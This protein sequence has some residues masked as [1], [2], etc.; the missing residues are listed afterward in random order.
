MAD[1]D[2][3]PGNDGEPVPIR[4][5][6]PELLDHPPPGSGPVATFVHRRLGRRGGALVILAV[7]DLLFGAALVVT[8]PHGPHDTPV[9]WP[10]SAGVVLGVPSTTWGWVSIGVGLFLLTG[11]PRVAG[12]RWQFAVAVA[13]KFLLT[14]ASISLWLVSHQA[15]LWGVSA[16]YAGIAATTLLISGWRDGGYEPS[17]QTRWWAYR[18]RGG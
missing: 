3:L 17:R 16:I 18:D 8:V 7:M 14:G 10:A 4:P 1:D 12:D 6:D 9:W 5:V 13:F 11:A 2:V 15:G